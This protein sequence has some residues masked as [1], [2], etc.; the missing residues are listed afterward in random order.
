MIIIV[1]TIGVLV[2][3]IFALRESLKTE[4]ASERA[5]LKSIKEKRY[6]DLINLFLLS[7]E[8][9]ELL[10]EKKI[11]LDPL[12]KKIKEMFPK[13]ILNGIVAQMLKK[14][15]DG[16]H[17]SD[18]V[19]LEENKEKLSMLDF[20]KGIPE[21]ITNIETISHPDNKKEIIFMGRISLEDID[22]EDILVFKAIRINK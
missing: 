13:E 5:A 3:L 4:G 9:E 16:W 6:N 22:K 15:F 12:N 21:R 19:R 14:D 8:G 17:L 7:E 1:S 20:K 18:E 2:G 10:K 11:E